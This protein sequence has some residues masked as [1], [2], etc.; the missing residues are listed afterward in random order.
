MSVLVDK[1]PLPEDRDLQCFLPLVNAYKDLDF[2]I[3]VNPN[4]DT[5]FFNNLRANRLVCL[6]VWLST[7]NV[8]N[9]VLITAK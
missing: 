4:Y 2:T 1:I 6:S 8:D 3:C 5:R 9:N 7:Q